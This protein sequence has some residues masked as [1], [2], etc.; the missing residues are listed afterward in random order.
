M[1]LSGDEKINCQ[2]IKITLILM[3]YDGDCDAR[4]SFVIVSVANGGDDVTMIC[5][6]EECSS[7]WVR[8]WVLQIVLG[9]S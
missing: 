7:C 8:C 5:V 9:S 4:W 1:K 6:D 3:Q 2:T